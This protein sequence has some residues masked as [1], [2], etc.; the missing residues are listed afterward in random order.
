MGQGHARPLRLLQANV[1]GF[2]RHVHGLNGPGHIA[3]NLAQVAHAGIGGQV[4]A[5]GIHLVGHLHGLVVMAHFH[6]G[7]GQQAIH[8]TA[9]GIQLHGLFGQAQA[10]R[11]VVLGEAQ[12]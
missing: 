6:I 10:L 9:A 4:G 11:E 1:A 7:V 2:H 8:E 12:R 3:V 5:H